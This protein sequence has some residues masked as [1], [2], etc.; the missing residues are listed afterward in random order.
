MSVFSS[1]NLKLSLTSR[2]SFA[3]LVI[4][5]TFSSSMIFLYLR[6]VSSFS[7]TYFVYSTLTST[8]SFSCLVISCAFSSSYF[9][10]FFKLSFKSSSFFDRVL[11]SSSC[12]LKSALILAISSFDKE[13][14]SFSSFSLP[15]L[16]ALTILLCFLSSL[17]SG[18]FSEALASYF[19]A[20][21]S[22]WS[23]SLTC[24]FAC[25]FVCSFECSF[26]CSLVDS[27]AGSFF[28]SS[29]LDLKN[30]RWGVGTI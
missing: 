21:S 6:T 28:S 8:I 25:S 22:L 17:T 3:N 30:V 24:S 27:F 12:S 7:C 19:F 9:S 2:R 29:F 13:P 10:K 23:L 15:V 5:N 4:A 1:E 20:G 11:M 26:G 18:F 14:S 16:S